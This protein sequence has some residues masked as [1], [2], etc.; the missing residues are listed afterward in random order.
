[1]YAGVNG[2]LDSVPLD[3]ISAFEEQFVSYLKA[4][5]GEILDAIK[6]KG[7]LSSDLLA[8]LK[9]ATETFVATF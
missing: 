2:Y 8:K 9:S 7:E 3:K 4:N 1:I 6:T 5:E